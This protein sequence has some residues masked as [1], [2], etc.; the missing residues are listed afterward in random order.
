MSE[1]GEEKEQT[2]LSQVERLADDM[3]RVERSFVTRRASDFCSR[4]VVQ[5]RVLVTEPLSQ[6]SP[7]SQKGKAVY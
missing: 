1:R 7:E 2:L 6:L 3:K 5:K 4:V